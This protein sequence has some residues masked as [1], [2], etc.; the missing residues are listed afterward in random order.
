M[1]INFLF[2][3]TILLIYYGTGNVLFKLTAG[4]KK[5]SLFVEFVCVWGWPIFIFLAILLVFFDILTGWNDN[6]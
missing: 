1:I 5:Y 4:E 6:G 2:V 3:L